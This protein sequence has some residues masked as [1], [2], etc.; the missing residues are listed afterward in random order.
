MRCRQDHTPRPARSRS[1]ATRVARAARIHVVGVGHPRV[2]Q[3]HRV[4]QQVS[5]AQDRAAAGL[6][7]DLE[8]DPLVAGGV[9]G[10]GA[11]G[12][13]RADGLR[14]RAAPL[15]DAWRQLDDTLR[16]GLVFAAWCHRATFLR[17]D[18]STP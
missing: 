12:I 7:A 8:Q 10:R 2:D 17:L 9:P 3:P 5:D 13:L 16:A 1:S 14:I 6:V 11:V 15:H 18:V 4:H